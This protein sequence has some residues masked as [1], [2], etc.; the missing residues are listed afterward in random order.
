MTHEPITTL[1]RR[2]KQAKRE[3]KY[4]E[5][6]EHFDPSDDGEWCEL[7]KDFAALANSGGG[8][9]V[10]GLRN[11]GTPSGVNVKDVL[12]LD[13]ATITDKMLKYTAGHYGGFEVHESK[14]RR[15]RLAVIAV[16]GV[17]VPIVFTR[18]GTYL[19]DPLTGKQK[20]A[21]SQ[22]TVYFRHGA[23]SEPAT[24]EDLRSFIA[25]RVEATRKSWLDNI[26]KL[27][28]AP[29]DAE[30]AIYRASSSEKNAGD[31]MRIQLTS[32]PDAPVYGRL[33]IDDTHPYRLKELIGVVNRQLGGKA[34]INSRDILCIRAVE[35][36]D[37]KTSP[38]F[39]GRGKY[40]GSP[41]YSEAF[42]EWLLGRYRRDKGFFANERAR[43]SERKRA[44]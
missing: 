31:P 35:N 6:K 4:V 43:F 36:V 24:S 5:F 18:P 14:R 17:P 44:H 12:A 7:V 15:A 23:K 11:D 21:F 41:Q 37:E 3:S 28:K 13:A 39:C 25:A 42:V 1:V 9:V 34:T 10:V 26:R 27:V 20:T 2:A 38:H 22:G 40:V 33:S 19:V 32:D 8:I 29:A 30:V 16:E